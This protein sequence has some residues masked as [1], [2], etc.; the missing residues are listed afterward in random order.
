MYYFIFLELES[1]F[2]S[3]REKH[4]SCCWISEVGGLLSLLAFQ[5][6]INLVERYKWQGSHGGWSTTKSVDGDQGSYCALRGKLSMWKFF[7]EGEFLYVNW[8]LEMS[9]WGE[10]LRTTHETTCHIF[11]S[12]RFFWFISLGATFLEL[13]EMPTACCWVLLWDLFL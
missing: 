11:S 4:G 13:A 9:I 5:E 6:V 10:Y 3:H 2:V 12:R 1:V 7:S 8:H